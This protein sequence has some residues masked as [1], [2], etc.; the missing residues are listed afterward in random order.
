MVGAFIPHLVK[1]K[2]L[3]PA[4]LVAQLLGMSFSWG[5]FSTGGGILLSIL[6]GVVLLS[7][8]ERRR[9]GLL[10]AVG[11]LSHSGADMLSL[12]PAGR[13]NQQFLWPLVQYKTPSPGLYLS[14]QPEPTIVTGLVSGGVWL[15]HRS[16]G[17]RL[18]NS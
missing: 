15:L 14:T 2:L 7:T 10:L 12:T 8:S 11:A 18:S 1:I 13:S 17:E 3:L 9:G 5:S 6:I 16:R 4:G